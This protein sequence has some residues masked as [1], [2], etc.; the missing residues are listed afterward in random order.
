[1]KRCADS[2]SVADCAA[3]TLFRS[4]SRAQAVCSIVAATVGAI[5]VG[6]LLSCWGARNTEAPMVSPKA[7]PE[8]GTPADAS[9]D[10]ADAGIDA[11]VDAAQDDGGDADADI[12]G[13]RWTDAHQSAERCEDYREARWAQVYKDPHGPDR[14]YGYDGYVYRN[15]AIRRQIEGRERLHCVRVYHPAGDKSAAGKVVR[16]S[17]RIDAAWYRLIENTLSRLP[18]LHLQAVHAFVIDDRPILHGVASFSREDPTKDAR[19]GHTI[20]LNQRLFTKANHWGPGNY[21]KYWAYHVQYDRTIVDG[22]AAEHDLFSPVLIHEIG[23]I[24]NYNVVNGSASDPTCP[25]C[26]WMCGDHDNCKGL[27]PEQKEAYCATS[28]CTG[29]GYASGTEN[30]SEMYRWF[31]QGSETRALL[32]QHFEP[33]FSLLDDEEDGEG[34]NGRWEAPWELGLG[35]VVGYRKTL[36]ESCGERACREF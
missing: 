11:C 31:Y 30:F 27:K 13:E 2:K 6:A 32:K 3:V 24:V 36:W 20:W 5:V 33:C 10:G 1:L 18:W 16:I 19:D 8:A 21:G 7:L 14:K 29:F 9:L 4:E 15:V 25:R 35:E 12:P 17:Q 28:Y 22:Y 26:A 23:H 34:L